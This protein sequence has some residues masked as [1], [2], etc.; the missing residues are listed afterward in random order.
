V[1]DLQISYQE[2]N[3]PKLTHQKLILHVED[4]IRVLKHADAWTLPSTKETPAMELNTSPVLTDQLKDF[5][6]NH[7]STEIKRLA[8]SAKPLGKEGKPKDCFQHQEWMF[9]PPTKTSD[10]KKVQDRT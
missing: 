4:K 6:A 5:L 2:G 7:T 3:L 1:Q 8:S 9:I 10:T